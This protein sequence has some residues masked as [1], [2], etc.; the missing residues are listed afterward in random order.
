MTHTIS[1]NTF[2][3]P[4]LL[5]SPN[6]YTGNYTNINTAVAASSGAPIFVA[7]GTYSNNITLKNGVNIVGYSSDIN[8]I[9]QNNPLTCSDVTTVCTIS[10]MKFVSNTAA[11]IITVTGTAR[12]TITFNN[13]TFEAINGSVAA[14]TATSGAPSS[15]TFNNCKFIIS[16]SSAS[17]LL[18]QM[19][20]TNELNFTNC[21][22]T[23]S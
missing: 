12:K 15:I 5:V 11:T 10:G 6:A 9:I 1:T 7:P 2:G 8:D 16:T 21:T 22:M 20:G 4:A 18:F 3:G 19:T 13:C 17:V 23:N 14:L